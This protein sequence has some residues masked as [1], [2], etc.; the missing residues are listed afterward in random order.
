MSSLRACGECAASRPGLVDRARA[1]SWLLAAALL[2]GCGGGDGSFDSVA[3][4]AGRF[5]VA[6]HESGLNVFD[7]T[8]LRW[9]YP[10]GEGLAPWPAGVPELGREFL[11]A[12]LPGDLLLIAGGIPPFPQ[13]SHVPRTIVYDRAQNRWLTNPDWPEARAGATLTLLADGR[14]LL[15]GGLVQPAAPPGEPVPEPV[16]PA[17]ARLLNA[18]RTA[19]VTSGEMVTPRWSHAAV[20]LADGRVLVSGGIA[21]RT[22][23]D[24][25]EIHDPQAGSWQP[26]GSL[27]AGRFGHRQLLLGDGRVFTV[28]NR[29][30]AP[31]P[32][33]ASSAQVWSP[34]TGEFSETVPMQVPRAEAALARLADGRVLVAGGGPDSGGQRDRSAEVYQPTTGTFTRVADMN[35]GRQGAWAVTLPNGR[36]LVA[37]GT[38]PGTAAVEVYDPVADSW[39]LLAD[40]PVAA[41]GAPLVALPLP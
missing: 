36:V 17:A 3:P 38:G 2:A 35:L 8:T 22:A 41:P 32:F 1:A 14:V 10:N 27:V 19:W 6:V 33:F 31:V 9:Q 12:P 13:E 25:A 34:A 26:T 29:L 21:D 5:V 40:Q 30:T 39:Q 28:G 24:S 7:S 18:Q 4:E 23:L 11:V 15:A 37:G 16:L 20:R